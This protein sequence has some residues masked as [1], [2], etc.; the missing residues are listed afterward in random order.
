MGNPKPVFIA[1]DLKLGFFPRKV[2]DNHIKLTLSQQ[3]RQFEAI[4]F[5]MADYMERYRG[6]NHIDII[7]TPQI[8]IWQGRKS[9]QLNLKDMRFRI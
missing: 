1:K 6:Q 3:G 5:R 8:N 4:G 2:G 7:Y 9:L